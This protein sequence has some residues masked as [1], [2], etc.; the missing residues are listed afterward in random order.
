MWLPRRR[1]SSKPC[2]SRIEQICLP[3]RI[4]S[5]THSHLNLRH[6]NLATQSLLNLLSRSR[7]K[8]ELQSLLQI[9]ASQFN[10]IALTGNIKFRAQ[11]YEPGPFPFDNRS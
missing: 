3:E 1:T 11:R 9:V 5:L 4:L 8:K 2:L 7:L 6:K 10:L